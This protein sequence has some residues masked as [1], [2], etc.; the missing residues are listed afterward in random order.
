MSVTQ[1]RQQPETNR[2]TGAVMTVWRYEI[3][4][5]ERD[6]GFFVD[7]PAGA[8]ILYASRGLVTDEFRAW[9]NSGMPK[10]RRY[11]CAIQDNW[12]VP[13]R[14]EAERSLGMEVKALVYVK[15]WVSAGTHWHL[16]EFKTGAPM[17][18]PGEEGL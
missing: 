4:V 6:K 9:V 12:P 11:F 14:S 2:E 8:E 10:E 7:M 18:E 3:P 1:M 5:R 13:T 16:F 15:S 17:R